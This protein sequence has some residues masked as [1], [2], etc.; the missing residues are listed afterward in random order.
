MIN[1]I[2]YIAIIA[3]L[4]IILITAYLR[5]DKREKQERNCQ[6][7]KKKQYDNWH[8]IVCMNKRSKHYKHMR[9]E[10]SSCNKWKGC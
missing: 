4:I 1:W 10:Y 7:C 3:V 8:E 6:N 5:L 9:D 2:G